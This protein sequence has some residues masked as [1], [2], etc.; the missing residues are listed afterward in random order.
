MPTTATAAH[1]MTINGAA[2]PAE[3]TFGC[4]EIQTVN[5]AKRRG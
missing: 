4:I 3:V 2:A 1:T 5:V